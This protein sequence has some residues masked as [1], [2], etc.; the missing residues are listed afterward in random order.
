MSAKSIFFTQNDEFVLRCLRTQNRMYSKAK[1]CNIC[2]AIITFILPVSAAVISVT[3]ILNENSEIINGIAF[4]FIIINNYLSDKSKSLKAQAAMVQ[5]Y[6]DSSLYNKVLDD[7][8]N[9]FGNNNI[10][11]NAVVELIV[12]YGDNNVD[13]F[14]NW[15]ADYSKFQPQLQIFKCQQENIYWDCWLRNKLCRTIFICMLVLLLSLLFIACYFSICL[16][17]L[18]NISSMFAVARFTCP[19][20]IGLRND[21]KRMSEIG[22]YIRHIELQIQN[23]NVNDLLLELVLLQIKI[24]EHRKKAVLIPDCFQ[25]AFK[26]T[27]KND[28]EKQIESN[29]LMKYFENE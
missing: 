29:K 1:K 4:G 2:E 9:V 20:I 18:L 23:N 24:M 3:G 5:Q 12:K 7:D 27:I 10:S 22:Y 11:K 6:I 14:K 16:I 25:K 15:Y 26:N 13:D 28:I 8:K 17:N 19:I 21:L